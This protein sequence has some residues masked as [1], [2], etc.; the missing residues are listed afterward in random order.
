M[1]SG[2]L[3][4]VFRQGFLGSHPFGNV[5]EDVD[6]ADQCSGLIEQRCWIGDKGDARS[7]GTLGE[8][9]HPSDGSL[10]PQ[11]HGHG[12]LIVRE[13]RAIAPIK[14][15]GP[16]IFALAELRATTTKISSG[17]IE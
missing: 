10:F 6:G 14:P 11:G 9:F 2:L 13:Q 1:K 5:Y 4:P 7:V 16:A 15:V 3:I 12:A 17:I 8:R